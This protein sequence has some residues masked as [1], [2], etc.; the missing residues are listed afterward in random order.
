MD[1][2]FP[3]IQELTPQRVRNVVRRA[4][5]PGLDAEAVAG[6]LAS[7]NWGTVDSADPAVRTMLGE[8]EG[9]A[10]A[11]AEGE[12]TRPEYVAHLLSLLPRTSE[13]GGRTVNGDGDIRAVGYATT[14]AERS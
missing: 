1:T 14:P 13:Q 9:W 5:S 8:M 4:T 2:R 6:F 7:V 3:A 11:Y 12:L 10:T